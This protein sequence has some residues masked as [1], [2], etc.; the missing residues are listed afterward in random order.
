[1]FVGKG[2]DQVSL[3]GCLPIELRCHDR[4]QLTNLRIKAADKAT[5][6]F[7]IILGAYE[8]LGE[9]MPLVARHHKILD[10]APM[11]KVLGQIFQDISEFHRGAMKLFKGLGKNP[12]PRNSISRGC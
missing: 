10:Q 6:V 4:D 3:A 8:S 7:D 11:T 9:S 2:S 12:S 1:M 5:D